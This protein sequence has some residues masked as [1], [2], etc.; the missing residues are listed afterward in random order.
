SGIAAA[1][2]ALL[3]VSCASP[4]VR[5][6]T[7]VNT[8]PSEVRGDL[9]VS[10][11]IKVRGEVKVFPGAT[12]TVRPGTRILFEPFDPDEDGVNDSRLVVEGVLVARGEP[13]A[14]IYF[15]S[16]ASEPGPGDWLEL[17]MDHSEGSVL[18]Y[19]VLEHSRYGL[20]VHFSS[21]YVMNC[22]FRD[23]IDGTRFG[24]SR[25]EFLFN[26]VEGNEGK[27]INLRDSE[28][29]IADNRIARNG[30][31]IFLFERTAGS[32]IGFNLFAGNGRSDIRFGDFYEGE[33]PQMMG[34]RR[35]D[36]AP[37]VVAGFEGPLDPG[38]AEEGFP[39]SRW[40]PGPLVVK[41]GARPLWQIQ[42]GSFVDAPPVFAG[43]AKGK[44]AVAGWEAGLLLLETATGARVHHVP[45][46][47]VTDAAPELVDG[48]LYLPSWDRKIR[49][50]DIISG[51]VI[52]EAQW[53]TSLAD[54]HRQASPVAGWSGRLYVGL[55]NGDFR[56]LDPVTMQW[57]WSVALD[58]PV[59]GAAAPARDALWVGTD[60]GSLY[61]VSYAGQI[62]DKV[63]LKSPVRAAPSLIGEEGIAV[64]TREGIL[65]R[66]N[67]GRVS[68]RRKLPGAGTYAA[69]VTL[70]HTHDQIIV[71]DGSGTVSS[72]TG[73]GALMWRLGLGSAVHTISRPAAGL[74]MAGTEGSGVG[75]FTLT[76]RLLGTLGS[77]GAVHGIAV[78]EREEDLLVVY[79]ARDGYVRAFALTLS[80]ERWEEPGP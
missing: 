48:V 66:L 57:G 6:E 22:V 45:L 31:G 32:V 12:L 2:I 29:R 43:E 41:L 53:D 19:C 15:T 54:D 59:R 72:F 27:G 1:A 37:V 58:G 50:V 52:G 77:E 10:G 71:G 63:D 4:Q 16:A 18:E 8:I 78:L 62:L 70:R 28:I 79:G 49:A 35:E 38:M 46:P 67:D 40:R 75:I 55:W 76:G 13:E 61:R 74:L 7:T 36:G 34:N 39:W 73:K 11:T 24:T 44:V 9:T 51:Q 3:F 30:H 17:R 69:P 68:W 80:R 47:D 25:F 26:L 42:V 5:D 20:H 33:A 14:P 65:H 21:G 23:N 56:E 64:V 60:E